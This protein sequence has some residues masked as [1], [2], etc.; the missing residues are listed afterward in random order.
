MA[1]PTSTISTMMAIRSS[2]WLS[3]SGS[4]S[5]T[6]SPG[7]SATVISQAETAAQATRNIT[8]EVIFAAAT[9]T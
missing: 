3:I 2:V 8:M 4:S 1:V 5:A 7:T 9:K 6:R